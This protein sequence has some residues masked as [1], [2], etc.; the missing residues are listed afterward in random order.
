MHL[1]VLPAADDAEATLLALEETADHAWEHCDDADAPAVLPGGVITP[2]GTHVC[3]TLH[4]DGDVWQSL[5]KVRARARAS[6]AVIPRVHR[7][8]VGLRLRLNPPP[9]L[10][11]VPGQGQG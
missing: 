7:D 5:Y 8:E 10:A 9:E 2:D 11:R 3:Y 6:V 1:V 4:F